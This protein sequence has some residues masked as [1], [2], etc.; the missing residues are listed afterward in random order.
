MESDITKLSNDIRRSSRLEV[1]NMKYSLPEPTEEELNRLKQIINLFPS[2]PIEQA[3]LIFEEIVFFISRYSYDYAKLF[4]TEQL[5]YLV[6]NID[7]KDCCSTMTSLR[8][9]CY[10]L[11][12]I[13]KGSIEVVTWL[14]E[15]NFYQSLIEIIRNSEMIFNQYFFL[16]EE[17]INII[18]EIIDMYI[19]QGLIEIFNERDDMKCHLVM[20]AVIYS[21]ILRNK[22]D[23][24][25]DI[26]K[27]MIISFAQYKDPKIYTKEIINAVIFNLINDE[28]IC[29]VAYEPVQVMMIQSFEI[30]IQDASLM[31]AFAKLCL[32]FQRIVQSGSIEL[33]FN[34]NLP[35]FI[36]QVLSNIEKNKDIEAVSCAIYASFS[37]FSSLL[38][39]DGKFIELISPIFQLD[40]E[41]LLENCSSQAKSSLLL[42]VINACIVSGLSFCIQV[43]T[44][45]ILERIIE[46]AQIS[47][48]NQTFIEDKLATI[49]EASK[50]VP[51]FASLLEQK[52]LEK[53]FLPQ[54]HLQ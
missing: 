40:L 54:Y 11:T 20:V 9:P 28:T 17:S 36:I 2:L 38:S 51:E 15:H 7:Y 33:I 10:L 24:S 25:N 14:H 53:D 42:F 4:N 50:S 8:S 16:I 19:N 45:D 5:Q 1:T 12:F 27:Q 13:A 44:S 31:N 6:D 39:Q 43:L 34:H 48:D 3:Y 47:E 29:F 41:Y 46:I 21:A 32:I 35:L 26:K 23:L 18:P 30:I 37:L 49:Y 22:S 52:F